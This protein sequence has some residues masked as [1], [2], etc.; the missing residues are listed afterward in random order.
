MHQPFSV[1][2]FFYK[3][4]YHSNN[5]NIINTNNISST[6]VPV[7]TTK[8]TPT[9]SS[10]RPSNSSNSCNSSSRIHKTNIPIHRKLIIVLLL[11]VIT[12]LSL[13]S[14]VTTHRPTTTTTTT[15]SITTT[16]I[17]STTTTTSF[18]SGPIQ[19]FLSL[20]VRFRL[21][22]LSLSPVSAAAWILNH[23]NYSHHHR[24]EQRR[25]SYIHTNRNPVFVQQ[26]QQ[27]QQP[28]AFFTTTSSTGNTKQQMSAT[29]TTTDG[30]DTTTN[31][32][33]E[34][35]LSSKLSFRESLQSRLINTWVQ[36][37][38]TETDENYL[39]SLLE[40][41]LSHDTNT[42]QTKRQVYNGHYI[43]VEPKPLLH[44]KLIL[45]STDV[46]INLLGFTNEQIL[47][48]D[49]TTDTT[50]TTTTKVNDFIRFVSGDVKG[51]NIGPYT[52]N[53]IPGWA[54]P[55]ALSIMGT[56][57]W[58]NCPYN[59]GNAYG[60]GRAISIAEISTTSTST[61]NTMDD[62][63]DIDTNVPLSYEIQLKGGGTTPFHRGADGRA[64]LRS[65]IREFL[66]SEAMHYLH[67]PT[68]RA[69]ALV[70]STTESI[71]RPWYKEQLLDNNNPLDGG[72]QRNR[73]NNNIPS[74][75]D[76]RLASY[77]IEQRKQI[78]NQIRRQN[79][80]DPNILITEPCAITTRVCSSFIRIGHL[81][82]FA[83]RAYGIT[84]S[85]TSN[86][87]HDTESLAWKELEKLIWHTCY[88][89]YRNDAYLPYIESNDIGNAGTI[90]LQ[91]S[92]I[93]L[94][95]MVAQWIRVGFA[96]YVYKIYILFV[97]FCSLY[98]RLTLLFI[99]NFVVRINI[100]V[101]LMRI[102]V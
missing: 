56:R 7:Y 58:N 14:C 2:T 13:L 23:R 40:S 17:T 32:M 90:L 46:A 91:Q 42:N 75:D 94:A 25:S 82:L 27:Q 60:D 26:Q 72:Q 99:F 50:T 79:K 84:P 100:E 64:V 3:S 47:K 95:N 101:I 15:S 20:P 61:T 29:T 71:Q 92:A 18:I 38:D 37:L 30:D 62:S 59:T 78:I 11:P 102:I 67:V 65:S 96:Q 89:E 73:N 9:H 70:V 16:I 1:L 49:D 63:N 33:K 57:Y 87:K 44:P 81:D 22:L 88:R 45:Y 31:T 39:K 12:Y 8:V 80:E 53:T 93:K 48:D 41:R 66:A 52:T 55:Y 76:P 85:R 83:R 34:T 74:I 5:K 69:L 24:I 10:P 97:C 28:T 68:T 6:N 77:S 43:A 36:Q 51:I 21:N 54:T 4:K 86:K 35:L 19:R 98:Q